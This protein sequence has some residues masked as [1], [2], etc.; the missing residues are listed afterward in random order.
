MVILEQFDTCRDAVINPNMVFDKLLDFPETVVSVFSHQ[1]FDAVLNF[2]GGKEIAR[3][4]DV[5][6]IWPIYEVHYQGTA[7]PRHE[8]YQAVTHQISPTHAPVRR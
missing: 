3:T 4:V 8:L 1:L 5:D 7:H 6:G 2:L